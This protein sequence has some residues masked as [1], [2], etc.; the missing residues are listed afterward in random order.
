MK[1][2]PDISIRTFRRRLASVDSVPQFAILGIASGF[3][4]GLVI[5]AFRLAIAGPLMFFTG[6]DPEDFASLSMSY[7]LILRLV[8]LFP[9]W[10]VNLVPRF[11]GV[12]LR[13]YAIGTL[14]G[15]IP[16]AFVYSLVGDG[17]GAV[18][19]AGGD[20][21]LGIIFAPRFL[22]PIIG[23]AVLACIPIVYKKI[24]ARKEA[25]SA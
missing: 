5:V 20:L 13:T 12:S 21:N 9:F 15:I 11:L 25:P 14:L 17:A 2:L 18:L 19:D 6:N 4:T 8:P 23:L 24:K 22:A 16:G 1:Y 10:L 7:L 3:V